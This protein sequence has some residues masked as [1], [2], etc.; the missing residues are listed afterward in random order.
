[1]IFFGSWLSRP[2]PTFWVQKIKKF[3][4]LLLILFARV[5]FAYQLHTVMVAYVV[6]VGVQIIIVFGWLSS[7]ARGS[8]ASYFGDMALSCAV[9]GVLIFAT[10]TYKRKVEHSLNRAHEA[11][12]ALLKQKIILRQKIKKH[13][14]QLRQVQLEEIQQMY[15][16]TELGQLGITLLHDLAN[17]LTSLQIEIDDMQSKS[18]PGTVVRTREIASHLEAIVDNTR[19]RLHG[20][21]QKQTFNVIREI[22]EVIDYLSYKAMKLHVMIEWHPTSRSL[23]YV[24][25]A[26]CFSQIITIIIGNA[27]DAYANNPATSQSGVNRLTITVKQDHTH[28]IITICDWGKGISKIQRKHLFRPFHTSKKTGMGLGLFIAQQTVIANFGGTLT[29]SSGCKHTEFIVKL[30]L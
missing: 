27:I 28:L 20:V 13:T 21:T 22:D 9:L 5:A 12:A 8:L 3:H 23:K 30:P 14:T 18:K 7:Q 19:D 10:W 15:R 1:M 25:D 26:T 4:K 24:G 2:L 16:F 11:E 29:L 6:I 17:H